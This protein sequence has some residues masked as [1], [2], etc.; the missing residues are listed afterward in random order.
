MYKK[1]AKTGLT[2]RYKKNE[3]KFSNSSDVNR[4]RVLQCISNI[5]NISVPSTFGSSFINFHTKSYVERTATENPSPIVHPVFTSSSRIFN[6]FQI[7]FM[8]LRLEYLDIFLATSRVLP[9]PL[10]K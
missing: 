6:P 1:N 8:Y 2:K 3:L 4:R 10:K 5:M 7:N 9:V